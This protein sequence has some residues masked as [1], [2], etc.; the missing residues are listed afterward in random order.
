[1]VDVYVSYTGKDEELARKFQSMLE[2]ANLRGYMAKDEPDPRRYN[3]DKYWDRDRKA[4]L[5]VP[6]VTINY[7][8]K[9]RSSSSGIAIAYSYGWGRKKIL[10]LMDKNIKRDDIR[11]GIT[12]SDMIDPQYI[13]VIYF[14]EKDPDEGFRKMVDYI[15]KVRSPSSGS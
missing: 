3:R 6:I 10:P 1:M 7:L 13:E 9:F 4:N 2:K 5:M 11:D 12:Y 8:E 14:D 15:K